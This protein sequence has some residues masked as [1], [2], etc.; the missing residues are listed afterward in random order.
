MG[1]G[2]GR[3]RFKNRAAA[4]A[5][6]VKSHEVQ[7]VVGSAVAVP[8]LAPIRLVPHRKLHLVRPR[9]Q[10][11]PRLFTKQR[12]EMS[13]RSDANSSHSYVEA[14]GGGFAAAELGRDVTKGLPVIRGDADRDRLLKGHIQHLLLDTQSVNNHDHHLPLSFSF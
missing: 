1:M 14:V 11:N 9:L 10:H 8:E 3:H 12:K 7:A 5:A 6:A 4:A 2:E 13:R